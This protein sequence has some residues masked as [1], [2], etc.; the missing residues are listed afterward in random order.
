MSDEPRCPCGQTIA[1]CDGEEIA[2][3]RATIAHLLEQL[4]EEKEKVTYLSGIVRDR[5]SWGNGTVAML[6]ACEKERDSLSA[7]ST[8]NTTEREG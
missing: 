4:E 1:E 2:H 3:L 7:Y 5:E 8:D 6:R